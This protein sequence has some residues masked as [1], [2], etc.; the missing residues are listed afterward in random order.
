MRIVNFHPF[1]YCRQRSVGCVEER[2]ST[3]IVLWSNPFAFHYPPEGFDNVQMRGIGR[4]VEDKESSFFPDGASVSDY[5]VS[6]HA[7]IVK[8]D[9]CLFVESKGEL[10]EEIGD[11]GGIN[12]FTCTETFE[13]IVTTGHSKD[14]EPFCSFRWYIDVFSWKLPSVRDVAF[15]ANMGF[16]TIEEIDLCLCIKCFKFLQL[17]GLIL[18]ELR[19]GNTPWTFSYTSISCAK[20]DKKRLKVNSLASLPEDC[21]H[22]SLAARTLCRSDSTA[23][24]TASSSEQS[25]MGLRPCPG[26]VCKPLIPSDVNRFTQ[27]LTLCA[28]ISVCSPTQTELKPSDLS[29]TARQRM[30]KQWLSPLRKPKHSSNRSDSVNRNILILIRIYILYTAKIRQFYYM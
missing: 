24:R 7:C 10:F 1:P 14:I 13:A 11:F 19:R 30:R 9:K 23:L 2:I 22:A 3:G 29:N 26:R 12:R 18:I 16:I 8:Y 5:C 28:V 6:V 4:N 17:L 25:M 27:P 15:R 20:A 21:C